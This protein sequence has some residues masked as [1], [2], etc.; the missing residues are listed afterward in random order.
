MA[1]FEPCSD[2]Y[3][4][5]LGCLRLLLK[6]ASDIISARFHSLLAWLLRAY[7]DIELFYYSWNKDEIIESILQRRQREYGV[8]K[9]MDRWV[10]W[11][12]EIVVIRLVSSAKTVSWISLRCMVWKVASPICIKSCRMGYIVLTTKIILFL[13]RLRQPAQAYGVHSLVLSGMC[14][15]SGGYAMARL[16]MPTAA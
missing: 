12:G 13:S 14:W 16:L 6:D 5:V 2:D 10:Q 15:F 8:L 4:R 3:E 11:V 9:V 1:K 7:D